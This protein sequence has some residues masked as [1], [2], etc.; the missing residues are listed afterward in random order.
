MQHRDIPS[1]ESHEPKGIE[2]APS[3]STYVADGYGSGNW[4][5]ETEGVVTWGNKWQSGVLY[6]KNTMVRDG[7]W[8]MIA[9]KNTYDRPAPQPVGAI[10]PGLPVDPTF[11]E[12]QNSSV[13]RTGH[14]YLFTTGGWISKIEVKVPE[15]TGNTNYRVLIIDKTDPLYPV[16]SVIDDPVL[17]ANTWTTVASGKTIA[18]VGDNLDIVIDAYNSASTSQ[19]TGGWT[20]EGAQNVAS[21]PLQNWN[22]NLGNTILR[23]NDQD[24]DSADRSAELAGIVPGSTIQIVETA[25]PGNFYQYTVVTT[26]PAVGYVEYAVTLDNQGGAGPTTGS[27]C[28]MTATI[29]VPADTKFLSVAAYQAAN[30]NGFSTVTGIKNFD[31]VEQP[32]ISDSAFGVNIE[33]QEASVSPDWDVVAYTV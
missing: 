1:T 15:V 29:P 2:S 8:T 16:I 33:F 27:T 12:E 19:V 6:E 23:I 5:P 22:R 32:G 11:I 10:L 28:T 30:P 17:T 13:V 26:T 31:G 4:T 3:G 24:L 21:P 7:D 20:Y 25:T 9:N 14:N 18:G